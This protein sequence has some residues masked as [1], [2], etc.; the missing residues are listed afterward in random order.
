MTSKIPL[1]RTFFRAY[2]YELFQ[3]WPVL[4]VAGVREV[5]GFSSTIS[6]RGVKNPFSISPSRLAMAATASTT[7]VGS[8][9]HKSSTNRCLRVVLVAMS[10]V[11]ADRAARANQLRQQT[12]ARR[13]LPSPS[14]PNLRRCLLHRL[15]R[16]YDRRHPL[17]F[18]TSPKFHLTSRP[19]YS[20]L[21]PRG[22]RSPA[23]KTRRPPGSSRARAQRPYGV[24]AKPPSPCALP[25]H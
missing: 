4:V 9:T 23:R 7:I 16:R 13:R 11:P 1:V 3:V 12:H 5:R 19:C 24:P 15:R 20:P 2:S 17:A 22:P 8:N 14:R 25:E 6:Y 10:H 21:P 18:A